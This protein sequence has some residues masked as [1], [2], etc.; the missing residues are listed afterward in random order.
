MKENPKITHFLY[1]PFTGLGLYGGFRGNRWLRNRI[2]IFKQFV[3]PSLLAQTSKNFTLWIS[4]R[5]EEKYN[6]YVKELKQWLDNI[7][8]FKTIFTYSGICFWDDK[9]P[10]DKARERLAESLHN[11]LAEMFDAIGSCD[12]VYITIQP[13]D[14]L[15][16]REM[17]EQIQLTFENMPDMQALGFRNGYIMNYKTLETAEYN[18]TTIPPFFTIKFPT[19]IFI[20]PWKHMEYTGP[21]KSHEYIADKLKFGFIE[22][23]GFTV[24]CHSENISTYFNHPFKGQSVS[25][26]ILKDF[27]LESVMP[28]QIK[29]SIRKIIMRK[30]PHQW[31]R[32]LRY[33]FGERFVARIYD[34][35]RA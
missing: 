19:P 16:H 30:L 28:L 33:I 8:D 18:P 29:T 7:K 22:K 23:R 12:Y 24:G 13:S 34:F 2:Q 1:C 11:S 35:L 4:W 25:S 21:Y 31:Q 27:G 6:P 9:Y 32:K 26:E 3:V 10:D 20:E 14:D 5:R 15:Y 17:V